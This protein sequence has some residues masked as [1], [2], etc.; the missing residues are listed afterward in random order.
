MY[1]DNDMFRSISMLNLTPKQFQFEAHITLIQ[2]KFSGLIPPFESSGA[3][4][5]VADAQDIRKW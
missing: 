4:D 3:G 5:A 1:L 2:S